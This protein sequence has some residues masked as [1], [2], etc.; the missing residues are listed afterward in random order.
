MV[1]HLLKVFSVD[2]QHPAAWCLKEAAS[3]VTPLMTG[4]PTGRLNTAIIMT[5]L[6]DYES[7]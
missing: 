1:R 7:P 5:Y 2:P 4:V 6:Q 3:L